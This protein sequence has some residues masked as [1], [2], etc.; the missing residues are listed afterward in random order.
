MYFL[1]LLR[2]LIKFQVNTY[3]SVDTTYRNG[4]NWVAILM[5]NRR[6]VKSTTCWVTTWRVRYPCVLASVE[7][8]H[9][10]EHGGFQYGT[11]LSNVT[12]SGCSLIYISVSSR[13][14]SGHE[15]FVAGSLVL[16]C[17]FEDV[18]RIN[19]E[20]AKFEVIVAAL[21]RTVRPWKFRPGDRSK[22]REV[23]SQ[24]VNFQNATF[25]CDT[26]KIWCNLESKVPGTPVFFFFTL[27]PAH[28]VLVR[29]VQEAGLFA[30][31]AN[32]QV[33]RFCDW[34]MCGTV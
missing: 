32:F 23:F 1:H 12:A 25:C 15:P 34:S 14:D 2:K 4:M 9:V 28:G 29:S 17:S 20:K 3:V 16:T 10:L 31:V 7:C 5:A 13:W 26:P 21:R 22:L 24:L 18:K 19:F 11:G 6:P 27:Q 30:T 33:W 8:L